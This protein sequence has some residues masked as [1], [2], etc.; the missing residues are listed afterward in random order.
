MSPDPW[1]HLSSYMAISSRAAEVAHEIESH[2]FGKVESSD[3]NFMEAFRLSERLEAAGWEMF[4]GVSGGKTETFEGD[5]LSGFRT[6]TKTVPYT[7]FLRRKKREPIPGEPRPIEVKTNPFDLAL[8]M[9]TEEERQSAR[10]FISGVGPANL[11]K[12][13]AY[14]RLMQSVFFGVL[15][16]DY[17]QPKPESRNRDRKRLKTLLNCGWTVI[18]KDTY[19]VLMSKPKGSSVACAERPDE[20]LESGAQVFQFIHLRNEQLE[21]QWNDVRSVGYL[22]IGLIVMGA[23]FRACS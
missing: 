5:G 15:R 17:H 16:L 21:R 6:V 10:Q 19:V 1:H 9:A 23:L 4:A 14:D 11:Q 18:C 12:I 3:D 2:E 22:I 20:I 13:E 8:L 7:S